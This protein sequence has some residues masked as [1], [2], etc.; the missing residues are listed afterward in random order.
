MVNVIP[1]EFDVDLTYF[2]TSIDIF[3]MTFFEN[4]FKLPIILE[5]FLNIF[6]LGILEC[7]F[8][9]RIKSGNINLNLMRTLRQ[10]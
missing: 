8:F 10:L 7:V 5:T 1:E 6:L 9:G 4:D 3:Y 2:Q